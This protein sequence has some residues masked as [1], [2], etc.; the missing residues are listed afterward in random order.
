MAEK[1][2]QTTATLTRDSTGTEITDAQRAL[3]AKEQESAKVRF[4]LEKISKKL[5]GA[6]DQMPAHT[7]DL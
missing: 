1:I 7:S 6:L 4:T 2:N 5:D 3:N